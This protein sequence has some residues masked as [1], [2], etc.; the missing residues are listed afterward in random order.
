M[1]LIGVAISFFLNGVRAAVNLGNDP[2]AQAA[3]QVSAAALPS[4]LPSTPPPEATKPAPQAEESPVDSASK[5]TAEPDEN[6]PAKPPATKSSPNESSP[7]KSNTE[8][9]TKPAV[10]EKVLKVLAYFDK[11]GKA[12]EG[13]E[14]GR[15]FGNFEKR[16]P[17]KD[18]KGKRIKYQEWDVNPLRPG[19]NRGP[20]RLITGSDGHAYYTA[21]HYNT[22]RKIR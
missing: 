21:D 20:E 9:K 14:G 19:V 13:Y 12:M 5:D 15:N 8:K 1:V 10:P 17:Q 6:P 18:D 11:N 4:V 7:T 2:Q 22:F 3:A 16:L